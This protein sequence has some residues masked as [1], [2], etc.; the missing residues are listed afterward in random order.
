MR[1]WLLSLVILV[2]ILNF[3]VAEEVKFEAAGVIFDESGTFYSVV[4]N[5]LQGTFIVSSEHLE[6]VESSQQLALAGTISEENVI[7]IQAVVDDELGELTYD[8]NVLYRELDTEKEGLELQFANFVVEKFEEGFD[9]IPSW[10]KTLR[11]IEDFEV[12]GAYI[13]KGLN[14]ENIEVSI[15]TDDTSAPK[16]AGVMSLEGLAPGTE[17]TLDQNGNLLYATLVAGSNDGV[18]LINSDK[19]QLPPNAR[20]YYTNGIVSNVD[21]KLVDEDRFGEGVTFFK[22]SKSGFEEGVIIKGADEITTENGVLKVIGGPG[23]EVIGADGEGIEVDGI[24]LYKSNKDF[25]MLEATTVNIPLG[26]ED[27]TTI[28]AGS[29]GTWVT[30]CDNSF[31]IESKNRVDICGSSIKADTKGDTGF[32]IIKEYED[33]G[34]RGY[35]FTDEKGSLAW[36]TDRESVIVGGNV[37]EDN[38][39][40]R[41]GYE[42][43]KVYEHTAAGRGSATSYPT[44]GA[45]KETTTS[46]DSYEVTNKLNS[47]TGE[48]E[49]IVTKKV[50]REN[51]ELDKRVLR[52]DDP[53]EVVDGLVDGVSKSSSRPDGYYISDPDCQRVDTYDEATGVI[54]ISDYNCISCI[55]KVSEGKE[56]V[57]NNCRELVDDSLFKVNFNGDYSYHQDFFDGVYY[58]EENIDRMTDIAE[59]NREIFMLDSY[60]SL[61]ING[62]MQIDKLDQLELSTQDVLTIRNSV[63]SACYIRGKNWNQRCLGASLSDFTSEEIESFE[64]NANIVANRGF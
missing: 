10:T 22:S 11:F 8:A 49:T 44:L 45:C 56:T 55:V 19:Y 63:G 5:E 21:F 4:Y 31:A 60:A 2:I 14:E 43:G 47:E 33:G 28:N 34:L 24:I 37:I 41:L 15:I 57:I 39:G 17:F 42:N 59:G 18:F 7:K 23:T 48:I 64:I 61:I 52:V 9:T 50:T 6:S 27:V 16:V 35:S 26:G 12:E 1:K 54:T 32:A 51:V 36:D 29:K 25:Y 13:Y 62:K 58:V 3:S 53:G 30:G 46:Y 40:L 20:M 38:C